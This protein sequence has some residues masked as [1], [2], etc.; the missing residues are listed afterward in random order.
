MAFMSQL[1]LALKYIHG[2]RILHRD[3]KLANVFLQGRVFVKLGDFG[4]ARA[5][6][7]E[8]QLAE[9]AC[10]TPYYLSPE[11]CLGQQYDHKSDVWAM[12][13]VV[14][15]LLTLRRPFQG[16]NLM[17]VVTRI[18]HEEC[19]P[20]PME[21]GKQISDL[22]YSMLTKAPGGRPSMAGVSEMPFV[23]EFMEHSL[24]GMLITSR[25]APA[26]TQF[27]PP[28]RRVA[29]D[30]GRGTIAGTGP[31]T[32]SVPTRISAEVSPE[33][34][35]PSTSGTPKS[36]SRMLE[37]P[38]ARPPRAPQ[39]PLGT[40]AASPRSGADPA[41]S[42]VPHRIRNMFDRLHSQLTPLPD[43]SPRSTESNGVSQSP[44]TP[45][46]VPTNTTTKVSAGTPQ[47]LSAPPKARLPPSPVQLGLPMSRAESPVPAL[48]EIDKSAAV[49]CLAGVNEAPQRLFDSGVEHGERATTALS[50]ASTPI[51]SG[52]IDLP[53][54]DQSLVHKFP[55]ITAGSSTGIGHEKLQ[56]EAIATLAR[57]SLMSDNLIKDRGNLLRTYDQCFVGSDLMTWMV[58][59]FA[60][61]DRNMVRHICDL[62]LTRKIVHHVSKEGE[63]VFIDSSEEYYRFQEDTSGD[64]LNMKRIWDGP[65]RQPSDVIKC[66]QRHLHQVY[67]SFVVDEGTRVDYARMKGAST[68]TQFALAVS[69]LQVLDISPLPFREKLA[70]YINVYNALCIQAIH[71]R[72]VPDGTIERWR[73]D[74]SVSYSMN[75]LNYSIADFKHGILRGNRKQPFNIMRQFGDEDARRATVLGL[76]DPRVHFALYESGSG[77]T[78]K[79]YSGSQID[80][81]LQEITCAFCQK[82]V[83]VNS[84]DKT[85]TLPSVFKEY[86]SDFAP[87]E[88]ELLRWIVAFLPEE[89]S[90][91]A[92][93][94][95]HADSLDVEFV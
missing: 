87:S 38:A 86:L 79:L 45:T 64:I 89:S 41:A 50:A 91:V 8:S 42:P 93:L 44:G 56:L 67:K 90:D 37:K 81:E 24:P 59:H 84:K 43:A 40:V 29:S 74:N 69:E 30:V 53:N 55:P 4:L 66:M 83:K 7:S 26:V 68:F 94:T 63:T 51:P 88:A 16:Q 82:N 48:N 61:T 60:I 31:N 71:E 11:L 46:N 21:C 23:K 65:I 75:G 70:F 47:P 1:V 13:C 57:D 17:A 35:T 54:V 80:K 32:T 78:L 28:H 27:R 3:L 77:R 92:L 19:P 22:T 6:T 72:G 95:D 33:P 58:R 15:E 76:L 25:Q 2:K 52:P 10:G 5:L 73:R 39:T 34:A 20:I 36:A 62:L 9:T 12:G 18:C 14:Y 85:V 49:T